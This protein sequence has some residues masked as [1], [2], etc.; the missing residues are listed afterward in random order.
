MTKRRLQWAITTPE[1]KPLLIDGVIAIVDD[2]TGAVSLDHRAQEVVA[3]VLRN[4]PIPNRSYL[5]PGIDLAHEVHRLIRDKH[6]A[7]IDVHAPLPPKKRANAEAVPSHTTRTAQYNEMI[8]AI[9][10]SVYSEMQ[11]LRA[12]LTGESLE[13]ID[14]EDLRHGRLGQA[15]HQLAQIATGDQHASSQ[16]YFELVDYIEQ[17]LSTAL[18]TEDR[19]RFDDMVQSAR[20]PAVGVGFPSNHGTD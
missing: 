11:L 17:F 1:G 5:V 16:E 20:P 6:E 2:D 14:V 8:D 12:N 10:V 3:E 15:L 19:A 7:G 13:T 18:S 9:L 4:D